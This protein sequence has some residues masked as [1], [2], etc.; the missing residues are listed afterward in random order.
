MILIFNKI[1]NYLIFK[2]III[3]VYLEFKY[4]NFY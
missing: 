3:L 1:K 4:K 2:L